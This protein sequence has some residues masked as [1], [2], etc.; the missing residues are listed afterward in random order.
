[1]ANS[2]PEEIPGRDDLVITRLPDSSG[3]YAVGTVQ[4]PGQILCTTRQE[5]VR[6]AVGFAAAHDVAVWDTTGEHGWTRIPAAEPVAVRGN[7]G[8]V[9]H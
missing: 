3:V 4:T 2:F 5:A 9:S 8:P 7:R 6:L 1:M